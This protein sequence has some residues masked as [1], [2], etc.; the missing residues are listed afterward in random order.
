MMADSCYVIAEAGLN[1]NGDVDMARRLTD[2]A[3]EAGA[4]AVKFQKRTV[5]TLAIGPVLNAPDGRFPTFGS[6]YREIR[7]RLEFNFDQYVE[8]KATVEANGMDFLCTAFDSDAVAF[9]EE[10]G[11]GAYKV[12]S[13]SNT[14]LPL[15]AQIASVGK[16]V[17]MSSG[18]CTQDELDDAVDAFTSR[19]CPLTLLHCVSAYPTPAEEANLSLMA[20]LRE[21][22]HVPVGY[23]GHE[24]GYLST[25]AAVALGATAVERHYTLD[26]EM[27]GFDHKISLEPGELAAMVRDIRTVEQTFGTSDKLVSEREMATRNKYKVSMVSIRPISHGEVIS[28]EMITYRNPGTGIHPRD[29]GLVL[30]K[31][32]LADIPEDTLIEEGMVAQ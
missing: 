4:D 23:S 28:E 16:H 32:A 19:S 31:P 25:L 21:R 7:E 13:H 11:V 9:L 24:I 18:A 12:A 5:D 6:T 2:V 1:H 8:L 10:L 22:Y 17:F 15:L 26:K 29:A 30:G 3:A 14:N 20:S 27:I